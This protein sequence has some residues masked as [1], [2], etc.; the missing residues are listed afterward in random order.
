[1]RKSIKA[2]YFRNEVLK[3]AL[4]SGICREGIGILSRYRNEFWISLVERISRGEALGHRR[5][6]YEAFAYEV[7]VCCSQPK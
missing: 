2:R 3:Q 1:M 5:L 6:P 4:D 7:I